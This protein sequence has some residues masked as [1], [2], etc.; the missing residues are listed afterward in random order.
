MITAH[1]PNRII[2]TINFCCFFLVRFVWAQNGIE[3]YCKSILH[4]RPF[5]SSGLLRFFSSAQ[6]YRWW[7]SPVHENAIPWQSCVSFL[8]AI[9]VQISPLIGTSICIFQTND[10]FFRLLSI[11]LNG[12]HFLCVVLLSVCLFAVC[13]FVRLGQ[14]DSGLR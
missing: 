13:F 14:T 2:I 6:F 7:W 3:S 8:L 1:T 4:H 5:F 10:A 11:D 9:S 12:T